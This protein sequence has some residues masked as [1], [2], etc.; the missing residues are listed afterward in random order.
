MKYEDPIT[1]FK[2]SQYIGDAGR[3]VNDRAGWPIG[4]PLPAQDVGR[5]ERSGYSTVTLLA[6]FLGLSISRPRID[7]R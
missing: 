5:H 1:C 7:A 2:A 6:R 3:K 4:L